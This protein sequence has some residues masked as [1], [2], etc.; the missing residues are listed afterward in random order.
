MLVT[1]P[2][3]READWEHYLNRI[4]KE[5][6][7]KNGSAESAVLE[8]KNSDSFNGKL[9]R[10]FTLHNCCYEQNLPTYCKL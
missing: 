3:M 9:K 2:D 1:I 8:N 7:W 4:L 5:L 6:A 10:F